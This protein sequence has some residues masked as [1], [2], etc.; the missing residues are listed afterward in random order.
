MQPQETGDMRSNLLRVLNFA[1]ICLLCAFLL[2]EAGAAA[3]SDGGYYQN[4]LP[5]GATASSYVGASTDT[6]KQWFQQYD[7]VRR[8][9][10]MKPDERSRADR[11]LSNGLSMIVPGP[12]KIDSQQLLTK[13]VTR[14]GLARQQLERLPV[15]PETKELHRGYYQYFTEAQRLFS[16]Y[17]KVQDNLFAADDSGKP[18]AGQLIERKTF[19]ESLDARNKYIDAQLRQRFAIPNYRY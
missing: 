10:Q 8:Q 18:I 5:Q 19:L 7:T 9:A 6:V 16:D 12:E 2:F 3:Q 15:L 11:L 1:A 13:L 4:A 14:Y 17:L